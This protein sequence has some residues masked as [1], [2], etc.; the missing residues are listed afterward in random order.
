[1][2]KPQLRCTT[3]TLGPGTGELDQL[4]ELADAISCRLYAE[5]MLRMVAQV[6][7]DGRLFNSCTEVM[8]S[9]VLIWHCVRIVVTRA[10]VRRSDG[11]DSMPISGMIWLGSQRLPL[12]CYKR[13]VKE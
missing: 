8:T 1:M 3:A 12:C 4:P 13:I 10:Q 7:P 6:P 9:F 5:K 11:E 2:C